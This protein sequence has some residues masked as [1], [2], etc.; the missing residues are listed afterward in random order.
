VKQE[1]GSAVYAQKQAVHGPPA[2]FT[3][4][5]DAARDSMALLVRL[6]PKVAATGHGIAMHGEELRRQL[7][8]FMPQFDTLARPKVGRYAHVPAT[9]DASGV[10]SVPPP[11]VR[12]WLKVLAVAGVALGG[13]ALATAGQGKKKKKRQ[14]PAPAQS[15]DA[16]G[17]LRPRTTD[18]SY[19]AWYRD[20]PAG[21]QTS[22]FET[23]ASDLT[24]AAAPAPHHDQ[25]YTST[26]SR[27]IETQYP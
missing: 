13:L 21:S 14:S 10:T 4:D 2:Y 24:A 12:P 9:A 25:R 17:P 3:P 27:K 15:A 6:E 1:S 22:G 11:L 8:A 7:A 20:N 16:F 18:G 26:E 19:R 5:W 23:Q